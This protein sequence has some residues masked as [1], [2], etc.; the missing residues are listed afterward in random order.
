MREPG[1]DRNRFG[2]RPDGQRGFYTDGLID[3]EDDA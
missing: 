1:V 3:V 2:C